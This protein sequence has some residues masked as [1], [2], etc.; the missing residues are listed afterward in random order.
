MTI[1]DLIQP[2]ID[3]PEITLSTITGEQL[4]LATFKGQKKLLI[5]FMRSF[6][7]PSCR[8][9]VRKMGEAVAAFQG[10]GVQ[11]IV[12][13]PGS[14]QEAERLVRSLSIAPE[15]IVLHDSSGDAYD[16]FSL[17]K[18]ILSLVQK[19]GL[20]L[21]DEAGIIQ[22]AIITRVAPR[23]ESGEALEDM[24]RELSAVT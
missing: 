14:R 18:A 1:S 19:S 23:W 24:K 13:G 3:A 15:I 12:I 5:F 21:V 16:A 9:F 6:N 4:P 10:L 22:K 11:L 8:L 7:C 20:F 17:N 2:N